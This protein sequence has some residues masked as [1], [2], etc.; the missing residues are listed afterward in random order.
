MNKELRYKVAML[1]SRVQMLRNQV[2]QMQTSMIES[3]KAT[4][5]VM[6]FLGLQI[7]KAFYEEQF[8]VTR[9]KQ[10][11]PVEKRKYTKRKKKA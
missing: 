6:K 3:A 2:N 7:K 8:I 11:K 10:D 1:E 9:V 5:A 4:D